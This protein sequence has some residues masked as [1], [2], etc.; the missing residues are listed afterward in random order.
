MTSA[1][2][3]E[4][5]ARVVFPPP[6]VFLGLLGIGLVL[7]RWAWPFVLPLVFGA[8]VP[9]GILVAV[10]GLALMLS[11][12]LLFLRT[13]QHPAPWKPS[14]ELLVRGVY[15]YTRNPMYLGITLFQL[16]L[17]VALGNGW[18]AALAPGGL[19]IVHFLAVLPEEAYLTEKF[20]A[21][22]LDYAASVR[23]YL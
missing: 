20:G 21:H 1:Q 9:A 12:R 14:P 10:A 4:G 13:G 15:A 17:G 19:L 7:Q 5:G 6:F 16:G 3:T 18:V 8:R 2:S 22:Y 23:R 11:A